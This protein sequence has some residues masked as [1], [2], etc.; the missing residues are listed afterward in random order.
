MSCS[1]AESDHLPTSVSDGVGSYQNSKEEDTTEH[2]GH[3]GLSIPKLR[4][5][6]LLQCCADKLWEYL[7]GTLTS[8]S[9]RKSLYN[10]QWGTLD[11]S[12]ERRSFLMSQS[13]HSCSKMWKGSRWDRKVHLEKKRNEYFLW[14]TGSQNTKHI[15]SQKKINENGQ[16][17]A[18]WWKITK[19]KRTDQQHVRCLALDGATYFRK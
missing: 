9:L 3:Y 6:H 11:L 4:I 2:P 1:V 18:F 15:R 5:R 14:V 7:R 13:G 16:C 10:L 12:E 17:A 8:L 19:L